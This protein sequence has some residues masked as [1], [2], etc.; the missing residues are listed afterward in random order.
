MKMPNLILSIFFLLIIA[1]N[2][3]AASFD[4]GKA[5]S[6]VETLICEDHTL[7]KTDEELAV[8]YAK[9]LKQAA[10]P[11]LVKKQQREWLGKVRDGCTDVSCL[12]DAYA[13][14]M[15][16][17]SSVLETMSRQTAK[18]IR[19][20]AEACRVVADHANRG[21]LETLSAPETATP[22]KEELERIFGKDTLYGALAYWHL[23]FDNDGIPDHLVLSVDGTMRVG[24]AYALSGKKGSPVAELSDD[25]DGNLDLS[26]LEVGG[27]YY[28]LSH[29]GD[30]MG[31]LWRLTKK[32]KFVPVCKFTA[33]S[34][35]VVELVVGK[36]KPVCSEARL[37]RV[38]HV[39]YPLM[40]ALGTL[41][42]E[43]RFWSKHPIDGLAQVDID[44][45]GRPDNVVRISFCHGGGRGCD[46]R[47]IAVTDDTRTNIPDTKLNHLLLEELGGY[48]CGPDLD[49]FV[50]GGTTYVD[51]QGHDGDRTIYRIKGDKAEKICEFHGR[52]IHD[53]DDAIKE[54]E[55]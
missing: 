16:A 46:A 39:T 10:D 49:V 5:A 54:S 15:K 1:G 8:L 19:S 55:E 7:S 9:T 23:D 11:L 14:R 44:N 47:Y 41:P 48:P 38:H 29:Y 43:N 33:R 3:H 35:P 18:P 4:C 28:V 51:A 30:R 20:D 25:D 36:E 27:R 12:K 40:H 32:G 42:R 13:M 22:E 31:K 17:L 53:L 52:L 37:G 45:D 6:R 26:V 24:A 2:V 21:I 50:H 34:E